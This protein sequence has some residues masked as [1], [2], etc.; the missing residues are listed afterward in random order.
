MSLR[1]FVALLFTVPLLAQNKCELL[2]TAHLP[3]VTITFAKEIAA[4]KLEIPGGR[5]PIQIDVPAFCRV[6]ARVA[7]EVNF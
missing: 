7:P 3:G 2:A 1:C 5:G 6:A 4:G